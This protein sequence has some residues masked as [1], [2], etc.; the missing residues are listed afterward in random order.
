MAAKGL[1][2]NFFF[3]TFFTIL[4]LKDSI[5]LYI[6]YFYMQNMSH[7]ATANSILKNAL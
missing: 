3:S 6:L 4:V 1:P 7:S 2:L 5:M